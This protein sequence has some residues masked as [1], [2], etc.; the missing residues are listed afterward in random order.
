MIHPR[1]HVWTDGD[2]IN[3]VST[4]TVFGHKDYYFATFLA[5]ICLLQAAFLHSA[6]RQLSLHAAAFLHSALHSAPFLQSVFLHSALH[7]ALPHSAL[8]AAT[9]LH[10]APTFL[11]SHF[12]THCFSQF[13]ETV[14]T[15]CADAPVAKHNAIIR[16]KLITLL[17]ISKKF[18]QY[19]INLFPAKIHL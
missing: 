19:I 8:Q 10:S 7:S 18:Y 1:T 12:C 11:P 14:F 4:V 2:A 13:L 6:L 9:L 5:G 17:F 3:R 15:L 16:D